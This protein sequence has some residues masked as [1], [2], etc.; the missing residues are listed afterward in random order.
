MRALTSAKTEKGKGSRDYSFKWLA[1]LR[2]IV[3]DPKRC[4]LAAEEFLSYEYETTKDGEIISGFPDGNDHSIDATRY[5]LNPYG[6]DG[7]N[8][9]VP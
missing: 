1:S 7:G 4:P 6:A 8:K 5:A 9:G 3:I 2:E